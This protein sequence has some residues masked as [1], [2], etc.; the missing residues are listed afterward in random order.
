MELLKQYPVPFSMAEVNQKV[1]ESKELAQKLYTDEYL[2]LAFSLIDLTTLNSTDTLEKG[3]QFAQNVNSFTTKYKGIPNVAAICV[4]PPLVKTV[5][6]TLVTPGVGIASVAAGFPSSQT[7]LEVKV[8]ESKKAVTDGATDIDIVISLGTWLAGDYETVF[9]EI[10]IIKEAIGNAHLKVILE[11]G[12]LATLEN[13]WNA[14]IVAM[15]AGADFI[16]TSTGKMDPAASPEAVYIMCEAI[17]AFR[18][19]TNKKVALKPAGGM[20]TSAD[21]LM[22]MAIVKLVLGDEWM[23]NRMFRLGASRL[24]NN[25][26]KDIIKLETGKDEAVNHF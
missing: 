1:A 25:L 22:Y 17:A 23:N 12:A 7:Y 8:L 14:S 3:R 19:K 4:Y 15:A 13:I 9:N 6:T 2:K 11:T 16:K 18:K 10:K 5:A 24:A 21:A 26:V 20:V